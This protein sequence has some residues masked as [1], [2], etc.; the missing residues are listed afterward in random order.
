MAKEKYTYE[1][2]LSDGQ[3]EKDFKIRGYPTKLLLLPNGVYLTISFY[4]DYEDIL[5]KYLKWEI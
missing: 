2:L 1:V 4:S 3:V 5:S